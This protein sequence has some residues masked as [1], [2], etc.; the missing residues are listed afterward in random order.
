MATTENKVSKKDEINCNAVND[1][2]SAIWKAIKDNT[3]KENSNDDQLGCAVVAM[4]LVMRGMAKIMTNGFGQPFTPGMVAK[5][6]Q[7][8]ADADED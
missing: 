5:M 1:M 4:D 8:I 7:S 2:E 3:P 6:M